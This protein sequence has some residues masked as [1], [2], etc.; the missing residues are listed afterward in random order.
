MGRGIGLFLVMITTPVTEGKGSE[1]FFRIVRNP[2]KFRL[3]MLQK[4]PAAYF[5]GLRLQSVDDESCAV[6]VPFKWFTQNPFRSTYFACLS[7]AAEMSTGVLA[8]AHIHKRS[9]AVSMLVVANEGKFLKK[10]TGITTF[11]CIDGADIHQAIEESIATGQGQT[12][13]VQSK[14]RDSSGEVVAE[15]S[16]TW[17]FKPKVSR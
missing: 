7:M 14:G 16:F 10:A 13:V 17:S 5:S 1:A 15:F 11:R 4:L 8:M 12:I 3:F 9:P 6:S 2:L